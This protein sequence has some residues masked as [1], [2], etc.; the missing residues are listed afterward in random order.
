MQTIV[1]SKDVHDSVRR[2]GT[3]SVSAKDVKLPVWKNAF[4]Q[5]QVVLE[6]FPERV[7]QS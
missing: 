7:Y 1:K 6:R 3:D 5:A 4:A 2:L